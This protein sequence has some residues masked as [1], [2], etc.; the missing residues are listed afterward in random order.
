M[1][2]TRTGT[3][4]SITLS[5]GRS[6]GEARMKLPLCAGV[7][8]P[9]LKVGF[10]GNRPVASAQMHSQT[11]MRAHFHLLHS[12]TPPAPS[13]HAAD[14]VCAMEPRLPSARHARLMGLVCGFATMGLAFPQA[15]TSFSPFSEKLSRGSL[16][17]GARGSVNVLM[18]WK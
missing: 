11:R 10:Q 4:R 18:L 16:S 15:R 17:A 1:I 14:N 13:A 9:K 12:A 5:E 6:L 2:Q 8:V 3:L 7:C